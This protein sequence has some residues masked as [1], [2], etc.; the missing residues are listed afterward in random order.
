MKIALNSV[1]GTHVGLVRKNNEDAYGERI[2]P[3][4]HVF[5]LCDGMGGHQ[6]GELA[7]Q[8]AVECILEYCERSHGEH[9]VQM[10]HE[11]IKYANAQIHGFACTHGEYSGM[12]TTCIVV[13]VTDA[14]E[15][16][17]AHVGDSRLYRRDGNGLVVITRDHSYVQYLV[18]IGEIQASEMESHPAKNRILRAL[19]TEE[20]VKPEVG[21]EAIQIHGGET[22][23]LCSDGLNGM[24]LA[25]QIDAV[26]STRAQGSGLQ[27]R[28]DALIHAALQAGGKDNVTVGLLDFAGDFQEPVASSSQSGPSSNHAGKLRMLVA[29]AATIGLVACAAL[30]LLRPSV[31]QSDVPVP[32]TQ[33]TTTTEE[34]SES[35]TSTANAKRA[36]EE[37]STPTPT[38]TP[39]PSPT[40]S[41]TPTSTPTPPPTST[42]TQT[43]TQTPPPTPTPTS[44]ET[45]NKSSENNHPAR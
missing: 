17:H 21:K 30:L 4:G 19:G 24:I 12:G 37:P 1:F 14:N 41:P 7:S 2:V 39:T 28:V 33:D 9:A 15:L 13:L 35:D 8:K 42:Q 27:E 43:Q 25:D 22:F 10:L 23:L 3:S 16:Y 36:D 29:A 40:P 18:D 34:P 45:Q 11:A 31:P 20:T 44:T 32:P 26:L 5:V 6:G 38:P